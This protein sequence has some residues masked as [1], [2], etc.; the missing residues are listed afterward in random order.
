[1]GHDAGANHLERTALT[2][3]MEYRRLARAVR[4]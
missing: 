1:V 4:S 3:A 2:M